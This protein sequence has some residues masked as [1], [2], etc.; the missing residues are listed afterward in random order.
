MRARVCVWVCV[1]AAGGIDIFAEEMRKRRY[2]AECKKR[3]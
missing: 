1:S 3:V 2:K